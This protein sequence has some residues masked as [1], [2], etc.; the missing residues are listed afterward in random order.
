MAELN[1]CCSITLQQTLASQKIVNVWF[2]R[3]S[4]ALTPF[5]TLATVGLQFESQ[6]LPKIN[7]VQSIDVINQFLTVNLFNLGGTQFILPLTGGGTRGTS[8]ADTLPS[9]CAYGY[10]FGVETNIT[11]PGGK[12]I[13]GCLESDQTDGLINAGG[14][15]T[16]AQNLADEMNNPMTVLGEL[17][18]P[19]VVKRVRTGTSPNY[20]YRLPVNLAESNYNDILICDLNPT[21]RSQVS[22]RIG[23]G[24]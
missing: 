19:V 14:F 5:P 18:V 12:R 22:R 2:F 9:F 20:E 15:T 10:T 17:L 6:Y 3:G 4:N 24:L 13:A 16:T 7:A 8:P 21:V 23:S 1:A 11:R